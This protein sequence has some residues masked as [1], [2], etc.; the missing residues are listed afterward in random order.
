M[1][2][3]HP[4]QH[5]AEGGFAIQRR[6]L[7]AYVIGCT[8]RETVYQQHAQFVR[9][10]QFWGHGAHTRQDAQGR[11]DSLSPSEIV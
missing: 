4:W 11:I 8:Q 2:K 10:Y 6:M 1:T 5:V 9:D 7:D 3:G